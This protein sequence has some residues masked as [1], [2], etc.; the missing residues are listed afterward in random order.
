MNKQ[1]GKQARGTLKA[2]LMKCTP[3]QQLSSVSMY[4]PESLTI[5][6]EEAVDR[7]EENDCSCAI[8]ILGYA[9]ENDERGI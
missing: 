6:L 8:P 2:M 9:I 5:P 3:E 1:I 7:M 4:S